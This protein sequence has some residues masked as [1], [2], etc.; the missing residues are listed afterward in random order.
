[1]SKGYYHAEGR[2]ADPQHFMDAGLYEAPFAQ[3]SRKELI[4]RARNAD[5]NSFRFFSLLMGTHPDYPVESCTPEALKTKFRNLPVHLI[6]RSY[7]EIVVRAPSYLGGPC[8]SSVAPAG[9][10]W[11]LLFQV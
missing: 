5:R 3:V 4:A 2:G 7:L 11:P 10:W 6:L 1:M 9:P 8:W